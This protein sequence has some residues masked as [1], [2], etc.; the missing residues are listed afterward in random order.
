MVR[1]AG[2][3]P[4]FVRLAPPDFRIDIAAVEALVTPRTRVIV[5]NDPQNPTATRAHPEDLAALAR[6]CVER[7]LIAVCDEV[8][9]QVV[10]DGARHRSL[11]D[12][13]GMRERTVKI[14]S[15]GKMFG[16][17]GWKIGFICAAP[18]LTG[19]L[20]KAHQFL[21]FTTP[22]NLQVAVAWGLDNFGAGFEA[23]RDGYQRARDRLATALTAEGFAAL[24]SAGTYFLNVDLSRSGIGQPDQ[25]FCLRAV[26][27]AGVAAIPLSPF[28][29]E[30]APTSVI[31]LCFAKQD[32][33]L[34]EAVRRLAK[35]RALAETRAA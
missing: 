14:G 6:L 24:P 21:C 2:G 29:E 15:A 5:L 27:E 13:P 19:V 34:D 25:E 16:L 3:T 28:Y 12:Y 35:A 4:R 20:A 1:R 33:V 7:D 30:D 26:K 32:A 18:A 10:F 22:P 17:T 9:E 31:R 8:W 11:I 23:L